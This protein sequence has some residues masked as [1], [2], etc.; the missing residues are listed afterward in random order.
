MNKFPAFERFSQRLTIARILLVCCLFVF[1]GTVKAE[2]SAQNI[3]WM[4][5]EYPPY[6]YHDN[7]GELIGLS[8]ELLEAI[9][10]NMHTPFDKNNVLVIPWARAYREALQNPNAAIFTMT[11][12]AHRESLFQ[13]SSPIL[14]SKISVITLKTPQKYE[15]VEEINFINVGVVRND[16]GEQLLKKYG[17]NNHSTVKLPTSLELIR[18][19]L[20]KRVD[21]VAIDENI[22]KFEF[23]RL[24]KTEKDLT[25]HFTMEELTTHFAFN[26]AIPKKY[27]DEFSASFEQIKE[28]GQFARIVK[29]Y[30]IL[31]E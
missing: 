24:G 23:A 15:S 1:S 31:S 30:T 17:L 10:A 18:M 20:L 9:M 29:N 3:V 11:R 28:N 25:I 8:V 22:A 14:I 12:S 13:F 7:D 16:I 26:K 4:T 2:F 19:L 6:N 21:V 5:E 27:V